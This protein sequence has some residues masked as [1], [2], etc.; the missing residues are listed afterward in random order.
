[1]IGRFSLVENQKDP[2]EQYKAVE[3]GVIREV[4]LH[5]LAIHFASQ[6]GPLC[7]RMMWTKMYSKILPLITQPDAT[8]LNNNALTA[9]II[10]SLRGEGSSCNLKTSIR[11]PY[12]VM[13][14][15]SLSL[16]LSSHTYLPLSRHIDNSIAR[17]VVQHGKGAESVPIQQSLIT[18]L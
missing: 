17:Q 2:N 1:M 5:Y 10:Y 11:L 7:R 12:N 3:R 4:Q 14:S 13:L 15:S 16:S 8:A 18:M 6:L 9:K